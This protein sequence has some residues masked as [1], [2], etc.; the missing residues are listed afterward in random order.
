MVSIS[1]ARRLSPPAAPLDYVLIILRIA[2]YVN[3]FLKFFEKICGGLA[4]NLLKTC[5]KL[6]PPFH[7][8]SSPSVGNYPQKGA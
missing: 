5:L 1:Y 6:A 7:G 2:Y 4:E 3:T 8:A